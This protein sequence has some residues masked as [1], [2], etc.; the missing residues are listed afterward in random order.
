MLLNTSSCGFN[1]FKVEDKINSV[2][3]QLSVET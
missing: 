3:Y 1:G 2:H